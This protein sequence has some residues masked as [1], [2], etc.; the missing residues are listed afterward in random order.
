MKILL[1]ALG[2]LSLAGLGFAGA[3]TKTSTDIEVERIISEESAAQ[4]NSPEAYLMLPVAPAQT[5]VQ[6]VVATNTNEVF[7]CFPSRDTGNLVFYPAMVNPS[8]TS[9]DDKYMFAPDTGQTYGRCQ[10]EGEIRFGRS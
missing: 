1:S 9:E 5:Q 7:M 10:Q 3:S 4:A 8:S 6:N 2:V